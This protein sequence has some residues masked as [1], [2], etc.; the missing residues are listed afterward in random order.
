VRGVCIHFMASS[1][2]AALKGPQ[3]AAAGGKPPVY[4]VD[5]AIEDGFGT[6]TVASTVAILVAGH[7][8]LNVDADPETGF[9]ESNDIG[10]FYEDL[11][12][13]TGWNLLVCTMGRW[14]GQ[15][16][17]NPALWTGP[18]GEDLRATWTTEHTRLATNLITAAAKLGEEGYGDD[19]LIKETRE[20]E[21]SF[22]AMIEASEAW[23][24][25]GP[26]TGCK[27]RAEKI[28]Q[29]IMERHRTHRWLGVLDVHDEAVS[30]VGVEG[31]VRDEIEAARRRLAAPSSRPAKRARK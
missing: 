20:A 19:K 15:H 12:H 13:R 23:L 28:Y 31:V 1:S 11:D 9:Y 8:F 4:V 18:D 7:S 3:A 30:F 29:F 21:D 25:H 2:A 22:D 26:G 17:A 16:A 14:L 5:G 27:R 24:Q 6:A 10:A